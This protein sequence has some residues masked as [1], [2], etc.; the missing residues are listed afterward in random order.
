M[1]IASAALILA[2]ALSTCA[3]ASAQ[4]LHAPTPAVTPP[5]VPTGLRFDQRA[6]LALGEIPTAVEDFAVGFGNKAS[7]GL[8]NQPQRDSDSYV[9]GELVGTA[10]ITVGA[11]GLAHQA[12]FVKAS[13]RVHEGARVSGRLGVQIPE[14]V[15]RAVSNTFGLSRQTSGSL[16]K[17][18]PKGSRGPLNVLSFDPVWKLTGPH[19]RLPLAS[20][21]I[22]HF[23]ALGAG[24]CHIPWQVSCT[25]LYATKLSVA[26]VAGSSILPHESFGQQGS[27]PSSSLTPDVRDGTVI[28]KDA[29][30]WQVQGLPQ[31]E[32]PATLHP[33]LWTMEQ[34]MSS[35]R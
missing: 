22:P 18:I 16:V 25:A 5:G 3:T 17:G 8:V 35:G 28:G 6:A 10:V 14:P 11:L 23:H 9:G 2:V 24:R 19:G 1:W 27:S 7:L 13:V 30:H 15:V 32:Y 29:G 26:A 4:S 31:L 12:G 21:R 33:S 20:F 34:L